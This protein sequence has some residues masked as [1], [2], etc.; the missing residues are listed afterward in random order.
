VKR[1]RIPEG[2]CAT[3][4]EASS[5]PQRHGLPDRSSIR[6]FLTQISR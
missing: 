6:Q 3:G 2:L 1:E 4:A 5:P